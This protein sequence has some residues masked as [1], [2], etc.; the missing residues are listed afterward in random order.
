M[1]YINKTLFNEAIKFLEREEVFE[2]FYD[3]WEEFCVN[4]LLEIWQEAEEVMYD[5]RQ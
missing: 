1:R 5:S 2:D 4:E 3:E